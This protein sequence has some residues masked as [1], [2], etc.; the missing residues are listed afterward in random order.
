VIILKIKRQFS[1][2]YKVLLLSLIL[3]VIPLFGSGYYLY[4]AT[5][6]NLMNIDQSDMMN[7]SNSAS[8]LIGSIGTSLL[9]VTQSNSHWSAARTAVKD[10]NID[11]LQQNINT[12]IGSVPGLDFLYVTDMQNRVLT[13]AGDVKEADDSIGNSAVSNQIQSQS[14]SS[15]LIQTQKGL[16]VITVSKLTGDS[17]TESPTGALIFGHYLNSA[18]LKSV[19]GTLGV[20]I[21]VANGHGFLSTN[22]SIVKNQIQSSIPPTAEFRVQNTEHT[23]MGEVYAPLRGIDNRPLASLYIQRPL[24]ATTQVQAE[25]NRISSLIGLLILL[26]IIILGVAFRRFVLQP[27]KSISHVLYTVSQ[28]D[29]SRTISSKLMERR[30]EIGSIALSTGQMVKNLQELIR[31]I[32]VTSG[33]LV[34]SSE[35]LRD[36]SILANQST[37]GITT[38]VQE[39]ASGAETQVSISRESAA[40]MQEVTS[41][42]GRI[43]DTSSV[44]VERAIESTKKAYGGNNSLE[45]VREQMDSIHSVAR[46]TSHVVEVLAQNSMEIGRVVEVIS[47]IAD[48]TNLLALNAAIEAAR[49]GNE[50]LGF[51]VVADEVRKLAGQVKSAVEQVTRHVSDIQDRTSESVNHMNTV[52]AE[53]GKGVEMINESQEA[54]KDILASVQ[55]VADEIQETSAATEQIS[56]SA[57]EVLNSVENTSHIAENTTKRVQSVVHQTYE[58]KQITERITD[59]VHKLNQAA[60]EMNELVKKFSL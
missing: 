17:G 42:I 32:Q 39:V 58:Q 57:Q 21:A 53:V 13:S 43:T 56:A 50:G 51:T 20:D 24:I 2:E 37:N 27:I 22:P 8:K 30:D 38:T 5:V 11:W 49:A 23:K 55:V 54:F 46:D 14:D 44:I 47:S 28:G 6:R 4:S 60:Q 35:Q 16:A 36:I 10:H 45:R 34:D 52:T 12:N 19:Q 33:N 18:D 7:T 59:S 29:L 1:L 41:V 40:A 48:Q 3:F 31:L 26:L 25:F 9:N 15:G